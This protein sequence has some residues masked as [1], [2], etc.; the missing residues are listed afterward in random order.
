MTD[1]FLIIFETGPQNVLLWQTFLTKHYQFT[2][3]VFSKKKLEIF[4]GNVCETP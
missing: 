3:I 4:L 1:K 2:L